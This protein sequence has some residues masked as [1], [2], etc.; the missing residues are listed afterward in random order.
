MLSLI[1][2]KMTIE[3]EVEATKETRLRLILNK[4][5]LNETAIFGVLGTS[6]IARF[7]VPVKKLLQKN[8][9]RIHSKTTKLGAMFRLRRLTLFVEDSNSR[10][11]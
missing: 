4:R 6:N 7:S 1:D 9:L 8:R 11:L 3:I 10:S 2:Q 5:T